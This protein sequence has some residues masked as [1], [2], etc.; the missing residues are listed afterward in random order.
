[1][2]DR[3]VQKAQAQIIF[4]EIAEE[5]I[6]EYE[7]TIFSMLRLVELLLYELK[8]SENEEVLTELKTLTEKINTIAREKKSPHLLA[9]NLMLQAKL[10]LIEFDIEGAYQHLEDAKAI[11]KEKD[12]KYLQKKANT[13]I[14]VLDG[15]VEK[16]KELTNRQASISERLELAQIEDQMHSDEA[17]GEENIAENVPFDAKEASII[18]YKFKKKGIAYFIKHGRETL[19]EK[20]L[21]HF[22][23]FL[24]ISVA[25]GSEYHTGLYGPY[26]VI[27]H[28]DYESLVYAELVKDKNSPDSRL[29]GKNYLIISFIY[30][31][32]MGSKLILRRPNIENLFKQK[33]TKETDI[34]TFNKETMESIEQEIRNIIS[35]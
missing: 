13:E 22:G 11:A 2:S 32:N 24:S 15:V 35:S 30:P 34:K 5:E 25:L 14:Q 28:G 23:T 19:S 16:W 8:A 21:N 1:M 7:L 18:A 27:G 12:L 4:Q 29:N 33:I 10:E 26:P 6:V 9:E 20:E 17:F 31:K 3:A